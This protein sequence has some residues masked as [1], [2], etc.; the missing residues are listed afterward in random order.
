MAVQ[1]F[2]GFDFGRA[3]G[4][5]GSWDGGTISTTQYGY[6]DGY[7]GGRAM[8]IGIASTIT[9]PRLRLIPGDAKGHS[10]DVPS[11]GL[12][13]RMGFAV[14]VDT[15][16]SGFTT[17]WDGIFGFQFGPTTD[18]VFVQMNGS[19]QLRLVYAHSNNW[20]FG[21][22]GSGTVLASG[23]TLVDGW[24]FIE[25]AVDYSAK[26]ASVSLNGSTTMSASGIPGSPVTFGGVV[27]GFYGGSPDYRRL[28]YDHFWLT[29]GAAPTKTADYV[30]AVQP[31]GTSKNQTLGVNADYLRGFVDVGVTR[32]Y[33]TGN[34][35][36]SYSTTTYSTIKGLFAT[37]PANAAAW[38]TTMLSTIVNYGFCYVEGQAGDTINLNSAGLSYLVYDDDDGHLLVKWLPP[39]NGSV[40]GSVSKSDAGL[41]YVELLEDTPY[42]QSPDTYVQYSAPTGCLAFQPPALPPPPPEPPTFN[43][44][45]AFAEEFDTDY[46]DWQSVT[47]GEEIESYFISGYKIN[48]EGNKRTQSNYVHVNYDTDDNGSAFIQGIWNYAIAGSSGKYS[49]PQQIYAGDQEHF[50]ARI[51]KLKIR[52]MGF[53]L[54]FKIFSES[55]KPFFINGWT[56]F[57]TAEQVP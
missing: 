37:N 24:N 11:A 49:G 1:F 51:R 27:L 18:G 20:T 40:T 19:K 16:G 10:I 35:L 12:I 9:K 23:G 42:Q 31:E 21:I 22:T 46:V 36:Q 4:W 2:E 8:A 32:Y 57:T 41:S 56:V 53:V 43:I 38:G 7:F 47:G 34:R 54:Q 50:S 48:A 15:E 28:A 6:V 30:S 3:G 44:G 25:F 5:L 45:L 26:T 55:G 52:G 14:K 13:R 33:S 17:R 29:D 39:T